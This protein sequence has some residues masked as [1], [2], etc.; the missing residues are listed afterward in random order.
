MKRHPKCCGA[1]IQGTRI[2]YLVARHHAGR[3]GRGRPSGF[4]KPIV[5]QRNALVI[6][7]QPSPSGEGRYRRHRLHRKLRPG[8]KRFCNRMRLANRGGEESPLLVFK[9]R[10]PDVRG[11][12]FA[13]SYERSETVMLP[14]SQ[15][16]KRPIGWRGSPD[17][18]CTRFEI[19][20]SHGESN[21]TRSDSPQ[22]RPQLRPVCRRQA[23]FGTDS[24][25]SGWRSHAKQ[26]AET[27]PGDAHRRHSRSERRVTAPSSCYVCGH[28]WRRSC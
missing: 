24:A 18:L 7:E 15:I 5:G 20:I 11:V 6:A 12:R 26:E 27:W 28:R 8:P 25:A 1:G 22:V 4:T 19:W 16:R 13:H 3:H 9:S 10:L 23:M 21:I 2:R 17:T 14:Y